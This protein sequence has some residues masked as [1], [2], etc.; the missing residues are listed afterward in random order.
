L[1]PDGTDSIKVNECELTFS[2][3]IITGESSLTKAFSLSVE[4]SGSYGEAE[5]SASAGYKSMST[6]TNTNKEVYI[7]SQATCAL[8]KASF[9]DYNMPGL[10]PN[11][12][13]GVASL[14]TDINAYYTFIDTFGTHYVEQVKMGAKY[15]YI[16]RMTDLAYSKL[17]SQGI[18]VAASASYASVASAGV[19]T[20]YDEKSA[21]A[22]S[23]AVSSKT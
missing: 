20:S 16:N 5:F 12:Q 15:G 1:I 11:F 7:T 3:T 19:K 23:S 10:T 2:S 14:G 4:A 6:E 22:F 8:Y 13:A 9:E 18:D 17:R 21:T